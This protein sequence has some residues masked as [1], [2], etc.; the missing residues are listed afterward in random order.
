MT[1]QSDVGGRSKVSMGVDSRCAP[2]PVLERDDLSADSK[3]LLTW[4]F[5]HGNNWE[6]RIGF[7]LAKCKISQSTWQRKVRKELITGGFFEQYRD[8]TTIDLPGG[9]GKKEVVEW[10]NIVTDEPCRIRR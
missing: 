1:K 4:L 6:F 3:V 8:R 5:M 7:A 2:L 10:Q 9:K